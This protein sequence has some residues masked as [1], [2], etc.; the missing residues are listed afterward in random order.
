VTCASSAVAS[1]VGGGSTGSTN[2]TFDC[3]DLVATIKPGATELVDI[4]DN[5]CD[6]FYACF[7]DADG[8]DYG[9]GAS[10]AGF[11]ARCDTGPGSLTSNDCADSGSVDGVPAANINPG[12]TES[13]TA[14]V[15]DADENCDGTYVCYAD[16]DND[17]Y[18]SNS[19]S[20]S[21]GGVTCTAN[22]AAS[23][24]GGGSSSASNTTF[25]CNDSSA[26]IKPGA[27][28][29]GPNDIDEN[30]DA[31]YNCLQDSDNDSYGSN[32]SITISNGQNC[33]D[34]TGATARALVATSAVPGNTTFD[35]NDG[36]ASINPAADDAAYWDA[37]DVDCD[38]YDMDV[39]RSVFVSPLGNDAFN[40]LTPA[41]PKATVQAGINAT[42]G[43]RIWTFVAA[44]TYNLS[45]AVSLANGKNLIGAVTTSFAWNNSNATTII[46]QTVASVDTYALLAQNI[47]SATVV[48]GITVETVDAAAPGGNAYGIVALNAP[49]LVLAFNQS[50]PGRGAAGS[51]GG[52]GGNGGNANGGGNGGGCTTFT[53]GGAGNG[54]STGWGCNG[55]N[56]GGGGDNRNGIAGAT[57]GAAAGG[58]GSGPGTG[59]CSNR[60]G[61]NGGNGSN[62]F[63]GGAGGGGNGAS[64][65]SGWALRGASGTGGAGGQNGGG[66]GGGSSGTGRSFR[67]F[68]PSCSGCYAG[69][70]GG[71]GG[72]G[73]AGSGAGAG[74]GG[75]ASIGL[76]IQGSSGINISGGN[77]AA[78]TGGAGGPGGAG[79]TGGCNGNG[80][81]GGGNA[82]GCC[83]GSGG[84]GGNGGR[85][86]GGGGGGGGAG[87]NSYGIAR[88]DGSTVSFPTAPTNSSAGGGAG[89]AGGGGGASCG[90]ASGANGNAG[91]AGGSGGRN[92]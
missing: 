53:A 39:E 16:T 63:G 28:E 10:N 35:C 82:G 85:G 75:G 14:G 86:G 80:G 40:G 42:T 6:G 5:N 4:Y 3:D 77:Y 41:A 20:N 26:A 23:K 70:G 47:T 90:N 62:G 74:T 61:N 44:G 60:N 46:R 79:G 55:G 37:T 32:N 34:N 68:L 51:A 81:N 33:T 2:T 54:G 9:A 12:A 52:G 43:S 84:R 25:D 73:Q 22:T 49:A 13:F 57:N 71:G 7:P 72:G 36:N 48:N 83:G 67:A 89:G 24:V 87:G 76:I 18:G 50:F 66:G 19:Q 11:T 30:C 59:T 45:S 91:G 27:T 15:N 65:A 92:F 21:T 78:S 17:G 38:G 31:T 69:G 58:F 56:G 29:L 8:D 1:S 64:L 88:V